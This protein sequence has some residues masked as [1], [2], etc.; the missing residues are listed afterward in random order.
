MVQ[1]VFNLFDFKNNQL[2][3]PSKYDILVNEFNVFDQSTNIYCLAMTKR[4]PV[5]TL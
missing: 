5:Q 3:Q 1:L 4:K 2:S